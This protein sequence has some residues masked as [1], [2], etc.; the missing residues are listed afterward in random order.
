MINPLRCCSCLCCL[1]M[2]VLPTRWAWSQEI[3]FPA[4]AKV[5]DVTQPPYQATPNDERDDTEAFNKVLADGVQLIYIPNGT[6]IIDDTLRWGTKEKRQI[7]Q[8]QSEAGTIIKLKDSAQGFGDPAKSKAM[9]WTGKA[10]AQ[11][12]RNGL[13]NLTL[14]T[15]RNN[16]GAIGA[17]F[18]ANNQGG[19]RHV[20]IRSGDEQGRGHIGLDLGYS[21]EQGPCLMGYLTV[22]GF[23]TGIFSKHAVDSV[24]FEY[25]TLENQRVAGMVND[26]QCVSFRGLTS[27]NA[28]PAYINKAGPSMTT[29]IDSELTWTGSGSGD[30]AV[31]NEAGLFARNVKTSG[32]STAIRNTAGTRDHAAGPVVEEF[33]SHPILSNFPS[34]P[35]SLGLPI[36]ETPDVPWD[37]VEKWVS[38]ADFGPPKPVKLIRTTDKK[39]FDR[40]D[41]SEALQKAIDSG[42]TTVYFPYSEQQY[43]LYGPVRIRGN[44][45]RIIGCEATMGALVNSNQEKTDYQEELRPIF[46]VEDGTAPVVRLERF[47][48][49]YAAFR[50]EQ[51]SK[52][53]LVLSSFSIYDL[54]TQP[55]SGDVFMED[56]RCKQ[57]VVN[58]SRLWGRQINPEGWEE[59]R[60]L[61]DGGQVWILGLKTENPSTIASTRNGGKMEIV[62]GFFY[63]NKNAEQPIR[64]F[65]NDN[66]SF[67]FSGGGS[68]TKKG[69]AFDFIV[70]ETRGEETRKLPR[71]QA[72]PRGEQSMI[73]LYVGYTRPSAAA[74][75]PPTGASAAAQG[76]SRA[77]V[78]WDGP[79][80]GADGFRVEVLDSSDAV[81]AATVVPPEVRRAVLER[82]LQPGGSYTV[83]VSAYNGAGAAPAAQAVAL[84]MPTQT[85]A[86][87]G[88][89]LHGEYF[90]DP[91]FGTPKATRVDGVIDFDWA[92]TRAAEGLRAKGY[93]VRWTGQIEPRFSEQYTFMLQ[94]AGGV[95]LWVDDQLIV[96]AWQKTEK[97]E[98]GVAT[99]EA[100][101]RHTV[102]LEYANREGGGRVQ[103]H[104]YSTNQPRE[105]IPATQMYPLALDLPV[106]SLSA[107]GETLAEGGEALLI[108]AKRS[109]PLEE[110]L[111]VPLAFGG[112]AVAGADYEVSA[113][114]VAFAA[115]EETATFT[116]RPTD[117]KLPEPGKAAQIEL[118]AAANYL[119]SAAT[120]RLAVQDDDMPGRGSGSGL[121]GTYFEDI[122]FSKPA[123]TRL[124]EAVDIGWDKKKAHP[125]LADAAAYA[126]RW[127]GFIQPLFSE[128]YTFEIDTGRN[129]AAK[130]VIDGKPVIDVA[131]PKGR[132]RS[133][134][135]VL[136]LTGKVRLEAGRKYPIT[137]EY[138]QP[139]DYGARVR[140]HWSSETQFRQVVPAQQL[141]PKAGDHDDRD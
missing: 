98:L 138:V 36:V 97:K 82:G 105:I 33:V 29:L 99:L 121:T 12:F 53:T 113:S 13:R 124:D 17:Q 20:T 50:I 60:I 67:S 61:N 54:E 74:P 140:L 93:S 56:M 132:K 112:A 25:V 75:A 129:N 141:Y 123:A 122:D 131:L 48:S 126:V 78:Q 34:P 125:Q 134:N 70:E 89:G 73:P 101:K 6:Y 8:G 52:R 128:E 109:G 11:R 71:Q 14:D 119:T 27:R 136:E 72:Y 37:P 107:A 100:G 46:I 21:D 102:R 90:N 92:A 104:W 85:A 4:G 30:A 79:W 57:I 106:V 44:V 77:V 19:I 83:R 49:W 65:H 118:V 120:V 38:V 115:G 127:E 1:A 47:D 10:P 51:R 95:R 66:S 24:T 9:I 41:W 69:R 5:V 116:V 2:L 114:T 31:I 96:D 43:G 64:M 91:D 15:G 133:P 42:A 135:E 84:Q 108:T 81:V 94:A 137:V 16:P 40:T 22:R 130:L 110:P 58:G 76:A 80:E 87:S 32:Y 63:S 111:V 26:G 39:D 55:G 86:G 103:L 59:P 139:R 35:R 88:S 7:L 68:K 3:V 18:I 45:R 117:D 23:D 62:G 28:V